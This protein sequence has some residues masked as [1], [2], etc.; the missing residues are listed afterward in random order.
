MVNLLSLFV[1]ALAITGVVA[2]PAASTTDLIALD[3]R[4]S[5]PSSQGTHGGYFYSWWTD[6]GASAV[7]TN[8]DGG[9]YTVRWQN[10]GNLVGGKGWKPGRSDRFVDT[11]PLLVSPRRRILEPATLF[12]LHEG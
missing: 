5:T 8:L 2:A 1:G 9:R 3:K 7:Y 4:Q 6:G 11:P 12:I 10:G